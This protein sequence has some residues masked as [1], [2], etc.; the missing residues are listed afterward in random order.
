MKLRHEIIRTKIRSKIFQQK[1]SL[2]D[3]IHDF[4]TISIMV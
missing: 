2:N 3:V 1:I 4:N